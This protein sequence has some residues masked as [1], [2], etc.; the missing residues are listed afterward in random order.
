[1][2]MINE[3]SI[4]FN[5]FETIRQ[6]A[7]VLANL[8]FTTEAINSLAR[9]TIKTVKRIPYDPDASFAAMIFFD[10]LVR[11]A[12]GEHFKPV[13]YKGAFSANRGRK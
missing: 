13:I 3:D 9:I 6:R 5:N 4:N 2:S 1:M 10:R 8:P 12:K 11:L 7:N